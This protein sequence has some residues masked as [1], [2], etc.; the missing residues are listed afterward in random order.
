MGAAPTESPPP[1][2]AGGGVPPSG[3]GSGPRLLVDD[4]GLIPEIVLRVLVGLC[5]RDDPPIP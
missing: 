3:S 5:D 4:A 1:R 2:A